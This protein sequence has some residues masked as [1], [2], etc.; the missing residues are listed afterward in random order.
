M[1]NILLIITLVRHP[2]QAESGH[3]SLY[4]GLMIVIDRFWSYNFI[5]GPDQ[6]FI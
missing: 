5:Q 3:M 1:F 2:D 4:L 6:I